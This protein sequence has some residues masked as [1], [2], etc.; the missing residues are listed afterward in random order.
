MTLRVVLG[1]KDPLIKYLILTPSPFFYP[2]PVPS[3]FP[4]TLDTVYRAEGE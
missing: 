4:L 1:L 2:L 3:T